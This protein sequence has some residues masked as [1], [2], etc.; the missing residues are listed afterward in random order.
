MSSLKTTFIFLLF[1]LA[2]IYFTDRLLLTVSHNSLQ[3]YHKV[4]TYKG[5]IFVALSA[6]LIFFVTYLLNKKLEKVKEDLTHEEVAR[7]RMRSEFKNK[8]KSLT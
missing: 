2:W 7:V 6:T 5:V 4:Q 8:L 3:S 1:G